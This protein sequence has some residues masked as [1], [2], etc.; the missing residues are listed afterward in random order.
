MWAEF[1]A[2]V[3]GSFIASWF[4]CDECAETGTDLAE[5]TADEVVDFPRAAEEPLAILTTLGCC[6]GVLTSAGGGAGGAALSKSEVDDLSRLGGR[7]PVEGFLG[8]DGREVEVDA[9]VDVDLLFIWPRL[10][11][12]LGVVLSRTTRFLTGLFSRLLAGE[13][14]RED[15]PLAS[16]K[17]CELPDRRLLLPSSGAA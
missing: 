17:G 10:L 2:A 3:P 8:S 1:R 9:I 16:W 11:K 15:L 4:A 7:P 12:L 13:V 6:A 14:T 5:E